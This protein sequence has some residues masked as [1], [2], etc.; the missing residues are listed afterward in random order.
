MKLIVDESN[1]REITKKADCGLAEIGKISLDVRLCRPFKWLTKN[2]F[3][4]KRTKF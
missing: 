1:F 4:C 2:S 3:S